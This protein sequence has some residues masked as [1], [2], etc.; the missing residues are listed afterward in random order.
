MVKTI[1]FVNQKGGTGKTTACINI[2]AALALKKYK[3]LLI[4]LDGQANT[5]ISL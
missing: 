5:T 2:A 4:D 3:I 1:A